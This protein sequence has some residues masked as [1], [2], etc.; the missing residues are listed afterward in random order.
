MK[1]D[2]RNKLEKLQKSYGPD[3]QKSESNCKLSLDELRKCKGFANVS[4]AEGEE[5]IES[6]YRLSLIAFDYKATE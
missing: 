3:V 5:I 1:T 2:S 4:D 6:L